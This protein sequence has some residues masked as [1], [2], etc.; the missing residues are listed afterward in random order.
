MA[1]RRLQFGGETCWQKYHKNIE[2]SVPMVLS[3]HHETPCQ[4]KTASRS[5][6]AV[7]HHAAAHRGV[8]RAATETTT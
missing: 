3:I 4:N 8:F 6:H 7:N 1:S 2:I 5:V